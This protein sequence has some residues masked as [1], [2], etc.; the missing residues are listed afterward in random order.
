MASWL[1]HN[2]AVQVIILL[3]MSLWFF[4]WVGTLF[5]SSTRV[6][7]AAAFDRVLPDAAAQVSEKRRVP[8]ASLVLMLLPAVGLAALYAYNTTFATYTLDAT[9]VIAVTYLGS[10][11][12]VV[13]LPWRKPD[14]WAASPASKFK[15]AGVPIVPVAGVITIGLLGYNL[16]EWLT[17]DAYFVNNKGSLIYMG[18]MYVLAIL[19][20]VGARVIRR[21]QG[22]DLGLINKEIPVE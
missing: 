18:A 1:I 10:A 5:L 7:F 8:V 17:N 20:Y 2:S 4:G 21:R 11:I 19:I 12:A 14:L 22:I 3:L 15:V 13:I 16:Y 6:I 9:L